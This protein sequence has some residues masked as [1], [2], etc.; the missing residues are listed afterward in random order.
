MKI[1][2]ALISM[3]IFANITAM[4]RPTP[5]GQVSAAKPSAVSSFTQKVPSLQTLALAKR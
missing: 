2:K 3:L 1:N 5:P 4:E